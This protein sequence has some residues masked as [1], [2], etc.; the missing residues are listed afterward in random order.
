MR[1][2]W[3]WRRRQRLDTAIVERKARDI[4][5]LAADRLAEARRHTNHVRRHGPL[6]ADEFTQRV[7][8]AWG[9]R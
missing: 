3:P 4:E 2:R 7:M 1:W 5:R 9:R 8:R 6:T